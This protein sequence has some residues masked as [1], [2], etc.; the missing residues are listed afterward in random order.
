MHCVATPAYG[1]NAF[2][3]L[4][5]KKGIQLTAQSP[6]LEGKTAERL[7]VIP[8]IDNFQKLTV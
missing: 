2:V 8:E 5:T 4:E 3:E 6:K 7:Q 1:E